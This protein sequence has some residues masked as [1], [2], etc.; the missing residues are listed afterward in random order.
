MC[1]SAQLVTFV[2]A[3]LPIVSQ[4]ACTHRSIVLQEPYQSTGPTVPTREAPYHFDGSV[5]S[6]CSAHSGHS[7]ERTAQEYYDAKYLLENGCSTCSTPVTSTSLLLC[8]QLSLEAVEAALC[9]TTPCCKPAS[10]HRVELPAESAYFQTTQTPQCCS[11]PHNC[12]RIV[13]ECPFATTRLSNQVDAD[14][15][16]QWRGVPWACLP[17]STAGRQ[18]QH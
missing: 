2:F 8:P 1:R 11:R 6:L 13:H 10:G 3:L 15:P 4:N 18:V 16:S 9:C 7:S 17:I 12:S 5:L 14:A